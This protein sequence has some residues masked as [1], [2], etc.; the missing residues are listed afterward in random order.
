[1]HKPSLVLADQASGE[2]ITKIDDLD[3]TREDV[4][5]ITDEEI[6]YFDRVALRSFEKHSTGFH[7]KLNR[8]S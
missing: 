1:M 2:S 7:I 8:S 4:D 3:R 6:A 5:R